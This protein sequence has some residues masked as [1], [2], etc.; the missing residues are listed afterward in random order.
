[1]RK[2]P[3]YITWK[4]ASRSSEESHA[5]QHWLCNRIDLNRVLADSVRITANGDEQVRSV[6]HR[7]GDY[8]VDIRIL[9]DCSGNMAAFDVVFHRKP[10]AGRFWKDLMVNILQEIETTP[11]QPSIDRSP[12]AEVEAMS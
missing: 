11:Q 2:L 10:E 12:N 8:F 7:L 3:T 6:Q 5:L 9:P 4:I 1:M